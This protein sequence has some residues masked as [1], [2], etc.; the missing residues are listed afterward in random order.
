MSYER[1]WQAINLEM[2]DKIPQVE[3]IDNDELIQCKTGLDTRDPEQRNRAWPEITR[4][5]DFDF[6]WNQD[7]WWLREGRYTKLG[8]AEWSES[9]PKDNETFCP[10][11]T[12][13]EV[14]SFDPVKEYGI[15]PHKELVARFQE[16]QDD[17]KRLYQA[18]VFSGGR[19]NT[20]FSACIRA[21]GWEMF[22][23]AAQTAPKRFD[24]VLEGF[25]AL[26]QAEINAWVET[27]MQV[28][29]C[30]D[31][32]VWASGPVFSPDW[33]R[34]YIFPRYADFWKTIHETGRKV[35]YCADGLWTMFLDDIACAGADGFIFEPSTDLALAVEKYGQ[36]HVIMGNADCR[37]LQYGTKKDIQREVD[38][39]VSLGKN[40]PGYFMC[41][42]NHIPNGIPYENLECYFETFEELRSR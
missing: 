4:V 18:A 6:A 27:D 8:H 21:F 41:V 16:N 42:S 7:E 24:K 9:N 11:S 12:V 34:Q 33:Y 25:A 20:L 26:T 13:E 10:F 23:L 38:R 1:G 30:H 19:Y 31:D 15:P 40:C 5:M 36:S 17:C 32:I 29:L 39:C 35:I 3:F 37:I 28:Y 22:M 14:L 2:P